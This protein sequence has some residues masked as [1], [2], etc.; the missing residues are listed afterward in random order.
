MNGETLY[1]PIYSVFT[2]SWD[3]DKF[4]C[5]IIILISAAYSSYIMYMDLDS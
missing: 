4:N 1:V 2:N 3:F 5:F